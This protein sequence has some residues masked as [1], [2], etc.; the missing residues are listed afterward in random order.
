MWKRGLTVQDQQNEEC[1]NPY[2]VTQQEAL[3]SALSA[4]PTPPEVEPFT[5]VT[6]GADGKP[7]DFSFPYEGNPLTLTPLYTSP[8]SPADDELRKAAE[9]LIKAMDNMYYTGP[10]AVMHAANPLRAALNK[11]KS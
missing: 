10:S 8:P 11:G 4:A 9:E 5:W 1:P 3:V 2:G 6:T 7:K